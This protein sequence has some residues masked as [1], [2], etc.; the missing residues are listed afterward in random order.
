MLS[1]DSKYRAI[2]EVTPIPI[3]EEDFS[4]VKTY[5]EEI[6][7]LGKPEITVLNRLKENPEIID[8]CSKRIKIVDFNEACLKLHAASDKE[9]L[10]ANF[11][12]LF[13]PETNEALVQEIL[14]V[15][16]GRSS[17]EIES[18]M[19][20]LDGTE[21]HIFLRWKVVPGYEDS[22]EEVL[23]TT[24]D[25]TASKRNFQKQIEIENKLTEAQKIAKVGYFE[26]IPETSELFWSKEVY[27][28]WEVDQ[29]SFVLDPVSLQKTIHLDD[30][31]Y[32]DKIFSK[33]IIGKIQ[34]DFK[35]RIITGDDNTKWVH[36]RASL[37]F[38]PISKKDKYTG[39]I[40]DITEEEILKQ[41]MKE[42]L[43][44][45]H[46]VS[47]ATSE[48]IY[49][50]DVSKNSIF[51]GDGMR[52]QF[53]YSFSSSNAGMGDFGGFLHPDDMARVEKSLIAYFNSK[54]EY[55]EDEYRFLKADGTY[56]NVTDKG[57]GI[58][59]EEGEIV[60][61]V[62]SLQNITDL[63]V[64]NEK[65][66]SRNNF[67]QTTVENL[68]IG[69]AVNDINTGKVTLMNRK[70]AEIY[71]WPRE[72]LLDIPSFFE[73]VYPNPTYRQEIR[74]M[75]EADIS[76]KNPDRMNWNGINVFTKEGK[77]KIISAKN[78][79]LFEQG[80][81]IS[82]VIDETERFRAK[83]DLEKSNERF[84]YA[85]KAVSDAI[86]DWDMESETIFWGDGYKTLFGY[87]LETNYVT[88][89]TWEHAIHPEDREEIIKS[90]QSAKDNLNEDKWEAEYRFRK[91]CG[92]YA[93]VKEK[94]IILRDPNGKPTRM[95][96]ALQDI[97]EQKKSE[98]RIAQERN[99]L[100]TL[101]DNIPDYIYV[102]D[103]SFRHIINNKAN[104]RLMGRETEAETLGKTTH[105]LYPNELAEGF[106]KDDE[107]VMKDLIP[108]INKEEPIIDYLG[109]KKILSTSKL[110]LLDY[111]GKVLGLVGISRDITENK[112]FESSLIYKT[113][114]L[115]T[116]ATVVNLLLFNQDWEKVLKECLEL[117]GKAVNAD[118]VYFFKNFTEKETGKLYTKQILE[119]NDPN[120]SSELENPNYQ[121]IALDN[122]P[123]FLAKMH[124]KEPFI[125]HTKESEGNLFQILEEQ[126]I[127]SIIQLP[128][129]Y[130]NEFYGYIGFDECKQE[131]FW[132]D[133]EISFLKTLISNL[134]VAIERKEN[135]DSLKSLNIELQKSN[136]EL[137][138]SNKELEQFA[139]VASHDLQEP[140][141][142]ITSFL[143]LI[144]KK[145]GPE[146]GDKGR[147]YIHFAVDGSLRMK[148]IILDLLEYS[149]VG[150]IHI[151]SEQVDI[152]LLLEEINSLLQANIEEN[153]AEIKWVSLP[154]IRAQKGYIRQVF[155]NIISNA[156][157]YRKEDTDPVIAIKAYD[158][159]NHWHFEISDNGLGIP[160]EYH[161][162]IFVIFQRLHGKEKYSGTGIGLA[163]CKK[164]IE[165][166]GG[167]IWVDSVIDIGSTFHFTLPK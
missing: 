74:E 100:R 78:I 112:K 162:K 48:I 25:I 146:L 6:K 23:V 125:A 63:K 143:T 15:T 21:K 71:G 108:V 30:K 81:M 14:C 119:W 9:E 115:E 54:D 117:V 50:W 167:K 151:P 27:R 65:L 7:L 1:E 4:D 85:T 66:R 80:L 116:I 8:E 69:I 136:Q 29:E 140:L 49:D 40:Q 32:F 26:F 149:R 36:E 142:M 166:I 91:Y 35:Y 114:L 160:E 20:S 22:F 156:L 163:I 87:P 86:W 145:Y 24:E 19:K 52:S 83:K 106:H 131:R 123:S 120:V 73:K 72:E 84:L 61:M 135:L 138:M 56:A 105:E 96:G 118:R 41:G 47:K 67:I 164:I 107:T 153:N 155:Q 102:K 109:Q 134:E 158:E 42:L 104:V 11:H 90:L 92:Q 128:I 2:F 38:D 159:G 57:F 68:P 88:Q 144:D 98:E 161:K 34:A 70:F 150:R 139:Y 10:L 46:L 28:I 97:S 13:L 58:R 133:E 18:K 94:T 148:N 113:R 75:I 124:E 122:F 110:P 132:T 51:W 130:N 165:N 127:K 76:S 37:Q 95:V 53:G 60:R 103:P 141:R 93:H 43:K 64:A 129:Y 31:A 17:L 82:T 45:Y 79:P 147:Q 55:W 99:L 154:T 5:L 12:K 111:E 126:Q 89:D 33:A 44:R 39:T 62:G 77:T 152:N 157:K 137:G 16:Q 121:R 101:I 3:W 59:N